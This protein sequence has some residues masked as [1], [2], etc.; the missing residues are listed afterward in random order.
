M[1]P[2]V[3]VD[4]EPWS[5]VMFLLC[6]WLAF[7]LEFIKGWSLSM[8]SERILT[9]E[10]KKKERKREGGE[11]GGK[12]GGKEGREG[13]RK[14]TQKILWVTSLYIILRMVIYILI[15]P[16][17]PYLLPQSILLP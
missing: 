4:T 13:E 3:T 1:L 7:P 16:E 17:R 15:A 8:Q 9:K 10:I 12:K 14:R 6:G 5:R 11:K 2:V